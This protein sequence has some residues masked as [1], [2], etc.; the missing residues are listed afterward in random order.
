[1]TAFDRAWDLVKMPYHITGSNKPSGP[2]DV[3]YQGGK[4]GDEDT[5]YWTP[6]LKQALTYA[7]YGSDIYDTT[8]KEGKP[9]IRV[10]SK[11]P[12]DIFLPEDPEG[13]G[14]G[15]LSNIEHDM[16][17][18]EELKPMLV[19]LM[20]LIEDSRKGIDTEQHDNSF[21][22]DQGLLYP[23]SNSINNY[24]WRETTG[25]VDTTN[26]ERIEHLKRVMEDM[27]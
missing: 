20:T 16:M 19:D 4:E 14:A 18:E 26:K 24:A 7:I 1:M 17:S 6:E 25:N 15:I 9:S 12:S 8:M 21:F 2:H 11:T 22:M 27:E 5:G 10:S 23:F 13:T 3:L